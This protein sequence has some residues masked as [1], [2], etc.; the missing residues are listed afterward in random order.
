MTA[1]ATIVGGPQRRDPQFRRRPVQQL[2]LPGRRTAAIRPRLTGSADGHEHAP[3]LYAN[4][5]GQLAN[6]TAGYAVAVSGMASIKVNGQ[7]GDTA[8]FYDSPGNDTFY[9]YADYNSSG[10]HVRGHGGQRIFQLGQRLR[11]E[12]RPI[13]PTAAR[14]RPYFYDSPG[15][16]TFYAYADYNSSGKPAAGMYGQLRQLRQRL[17]QRGQRL[18]HERRLLRPTAAAIRPISTIRRATTPTLPTPI[19]TAA[20]KPSAGMTGSY[21]GGYSNSASG[22]GTN[23]GYS[24][25][26]GSDTAYF[27]DSPGSNTFYA[28]A[29]YQRQRPAVGGDVRQYGGGYANS[30]T[31]FATNIAY[32]TTAAATRPISTTRRATTRSMPTRITSAAARPMPAC[33]AAGMPIWPRA[34]AP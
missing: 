32:A 21:G 9:A 17:C 14:I 3:L 19:T 13:R 22:F 20:G 23:V 16:D 34:S 18:R 12:R 24:S 30:A 33:T 26:G 4:G 31:G 28:Y 6:S 5:S 29:D 15:N 11:H 8:Q 1:A 25:N 10:E 27:Y 2:C 7:P